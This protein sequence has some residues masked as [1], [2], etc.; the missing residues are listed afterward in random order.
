M[1]DGDL[2]PVAYCTKRAL[3][4]GK[5]E[6]LRNGVAHGILGEEEGV[7]CIKYPPSKHGWSDFYEL[8]VE[9]FLTLEEAVDHVE[10]QQQEQIA[11]LQKKIDKLLKLNIKVEE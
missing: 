7:S 2:V 11:K 10:K 8:D 1:K 6:V 5:I 9:I 3:A 4:S